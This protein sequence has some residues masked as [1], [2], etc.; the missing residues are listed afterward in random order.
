MKIN[1]GLPAIF[2]DQRIDYGDIALLVLIGV[3]GQIFLIANPGYYS[4]DEWQRF[5]H[6]INNG[7]IS[8]V[9]QHSQ[10]YAGN[11]F[12]TPIRPIA[13]FLQGIH[14]LFFADFPFVVHLISAA[15][16]IIISLIIYFSCLNFG[17]A[18]R[19]GLI[20]GLFF[21]LNPLTVLAT[22]WS[23]ALMDQLYVTF[24]L[25]VLLLAVRYI[26]DET[27][28]MLFLGLI[29]VGGVFSVLSKETGIVFPASVLLLAALFPGQL[30][31]RWRR[32]LLVFSSWST[33]IILYLLF[34]ISAIESS[35]VGGTADP[36]AASVLN[37]GRNIFIYW[38]YPFHP[39]IT[40]AHNWV[41][42]ATWS[43]VLS[44]VF[45]TLLVLI[46]G[47]CH[48]FRYAAVY[49]ASYFLFLTPVLFL[50]NQGSHYMYASGVPLSIALALLIVNKSKL[51][52]LFS[53]LGAIILI[54]HA[55]VFQ[56]L[57]YETGL[58]MTRVST[59][60]K[61]GF[62]SAGYPSD[63]FFTS[64]YDAPT[65]VLLRLVHGRNQVGEY[66]NIAF[67]PP[68][69]SKQPGADSF[70][71]NLNSQCL[72]SV[73]SLSLEV[74]DFGP[75]STTVGVNPNKQPDGSM[76]VWI[77]LNST[78]GLSHAQ[79]YFDGE[80]AVGTSVGDKI[81]TAA[82]DS[83]YLARPGK[84]GVSLK[85]PTREKIYQVGIFEVRV[86]E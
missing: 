79:V 25:I 49:V 8:Y 19:A 30:L 35:F 77:K 58:C 31:S 44:F 71:L 39:Y 4:H 26:F 20:A 7:F 34:R 33:P 45:H 73:A 60:L 37:F 18:K 59:S 36:Y 72:L 54:W 11:S 61:A 74:D 40:E 70:I 43:V 84:Y 2:P 28:G 6:Y 75:Q 17:L 9:I 85:V 24:G 46:L 52:K 29:A 16:T 76:G 55:F 68:S 86:S 65:H 27:K 41:L 10:I 48:G 78:Q 42:Q 83:K 66:N 69:S 15:N 22:G 5:D 64:D 12:G 32:L 51:I 82:I 67:H 14:N 57:I 21:I 38:I 56:K 50:H 47:F 63:I 1:L 53:I 81:I 13:F 3:L 80:P 23:A 62:A